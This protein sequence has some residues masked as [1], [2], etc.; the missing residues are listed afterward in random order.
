MIQTKEINK[1]IKN[2][3]SESSQVDLMEGKPG[4]STLQRKYLK[5]LN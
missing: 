4:I 2:Q 3:F 5:V 1:P